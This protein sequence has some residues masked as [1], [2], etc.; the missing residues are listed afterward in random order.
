MYRKWGAVTNR[1]QDNLWYTNSILES[2]TNDG[3]QQVYWKQRSI[4]VTKCV[5]SKERISE[6]RI[7]QNYHQKGRISE[8]RIFQEIRILEEIKLITMYPSCFYPP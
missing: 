3:I 5:L 7:F 8:K 1:P 4:C 6:K 2:E